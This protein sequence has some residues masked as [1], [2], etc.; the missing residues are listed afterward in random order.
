M[1]IIES[2]LQLLDSIDFPALQ[3][4]L[5][6]LSKNWAQ[7]ICEKI[8]HD[9]ALDAGLKEGLKVMKIYNVFNGTL[10]NSF[11]QLTVWRHGQAL[12]E[13]LTAALSKAIPQQQPATA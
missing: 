12:K 9:P 11:W 7:L 8:A 13:E 3:K 1:N 5:R 2:P 4:E 10:K 6:K